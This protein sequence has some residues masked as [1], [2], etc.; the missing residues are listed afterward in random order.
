VTD[1]PLEVPLEDAV[2][3]EEI[4]LLTELIVAATDHDE[5][6]DTDQVDMA[7]GLLPSRKAKD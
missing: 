5:P 3:I 6:L 4:G 2:L 1:D 7:L